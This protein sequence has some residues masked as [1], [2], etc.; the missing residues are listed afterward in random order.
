MP[1][2]P[3]VFV[4]W[5]RSSCRGWSSGRGLFNGSSVACVAP[6]LV[7]LGQVRVDKLFVKRLL[8]EQ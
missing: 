6:A 2:G 4:L 5:N 7:G 1:P 8:F 3:F